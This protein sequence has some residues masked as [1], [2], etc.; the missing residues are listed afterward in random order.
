M[1]V[2]DYFHKHQQALQFAVHNVTESDL[3]RIADLIQHNTGKLFFTGIGKNG[4]VAAK[5]ASTFCSI[6]YAAHFVNPVDAMHGDL[7]AIS[8]G[9]LIIAVSKSGQTSE[10]LS[11]L[12]QAYRKQARLVMIHSN[13]HFNLDQV[14]HHLYLPVESECDDLNLIPTASI[15]V[16]TAFLQSVACELAHRQ[17][18]TVS[19]FVFNHPGGTIG[20]SAN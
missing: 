2:I 1:S 15:V 4:H 8:A 14:H 13:K 12:H 7:G 20:K 9:D 10:L 16:F 3:A 11:F 6:G 5:A 19:Q 18:L 17:N